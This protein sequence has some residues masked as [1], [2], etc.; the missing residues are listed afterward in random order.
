MQLDIHKVPF[1]ELK[2]LL[3]VC[4]TMHSGITQSVT[5]LCNA[6]IVID[7]HTGLLQVLGSLEQLLSGSLSV[8]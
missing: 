8:I 2:H 1:L 4:A 6:Q 7:Y 5:V 3:E